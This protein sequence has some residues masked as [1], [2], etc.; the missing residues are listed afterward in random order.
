MKDMN[1]IK[2]T[3]FTIM[4]LSITVCNAAFAAGKTALVL[5]AKEFIQPFF[6]LI[7]VICMIYA[8]FFL[9]SKLTGYNMRK[10]SKLSKKKIEDSKISLISHLS[11]GQNKSVDVIEI[12]GQRLLLGVCSDKITLLKEIDSKSGMAQGDVD[13]DIFEI[14]EIEEVEPEEDSDSKINEMFYKYLRKTNDKQN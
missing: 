13:D 3:V 8:S 2:K 7:F 14:K 11:L 10:F 4:L 9:Y 6:S 5:S 12:N 1:K